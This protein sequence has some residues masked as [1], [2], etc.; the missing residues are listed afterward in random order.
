VHNAGHYPDTMTLRDAL[1][2]SSN[3]YFVALEDEFFG[4]RLGPVVDTA[5]HLGLDRLTR[6]LN[7]SAGASIAREVVRSG[8][9]T[10]TLGQEPTSALELTGAFGAAANDGVLCPPRPVLR[11][12][13]SGGH[14]VPVRQSRCHRVLTPYVA[15]TLISLMRRDTRSGTAASY[16]RGWYDRNGSDVA[17]KTGTD[18][19]SADTGNSALWFV[20]TTPRLVAAASLVNPR[21]PKQTVHDLPGLPGTN[22]GQDVFGAYASTYWLS[23]YGPALRHHWSWPSPSAVHGGRAVPRVIGQHLDSAVSTLRRAGFRAT[24]FPVR[25]G[26]ALPAGVVAY[27]QPPSAVAGSTVTICLS[28]GTKPYVYVP[29]PPAPAPPHRHTVR[30]KPRPHPPGHGHGHGPG[31]GH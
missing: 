25:C 1:P 24:V 18:N 5:V 21:N 26:S 14:N 2:Q 3:T 16:F 9:P 28:S 4:C 23:A 15:R 20:G 10:F 8:E 17:G 11:I 19:N 12:T 13:D 7:S 6:P 22:V 29:P 30:P 31:H 27:Q